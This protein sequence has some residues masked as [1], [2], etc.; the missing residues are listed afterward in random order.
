MAE[1]LQQLTLEAGNFPPEV[2]M[3]MTEEFNSNIAGAGDEAVETAARRGAAALKMGAAT[4]RDGIR[5]AKEG[6]DHAQEH[7]G[8]G[9]DYVRELS[10]SLNDFVVRQPFIAIAGAFVIGYLAARMLRRV[11]S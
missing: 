3:K 10:G 9:L 2:Q 6:L 1:E 7:L 5:A 8:D 4:A 11:S